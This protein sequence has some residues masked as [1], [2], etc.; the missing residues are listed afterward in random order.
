MKVSG[1]FVHRLPLL[2]AHGEITGAVLYVGGAAA[3][4]QHRRAHIVHR[5][6]EPL[7]AHAGD[8]LAFQHSMYVVIGERAAVRVHGGGSVDDAVGDAA[9][10]PLGGVL[11]G[12]A[13]VH[14]DGGVADFQ[15]ANVLG[16]G[17]LV[18]VD[19]GMGE[20]AWG[21]EVRHRY[22]RPLKTFCPQADTN[23]Y[24]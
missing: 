19:G 20:G 11:L 8:A 7:A 2:R 15:Q 10:G 22:H 18:G 4:G 13:L 5:A 6:A 21:E 14:V 16:V 17:V 23:I 1:G 24:M 3:D 9:V 12:D